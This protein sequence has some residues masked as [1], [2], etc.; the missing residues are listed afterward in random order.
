MQE[1]AG[2][3]PLSREEKESS[4]PQLLLKRLNLKRKPQRRQ[5]R[6][7]TKEQEQHQKYYLISALSGT[8]TKSEEIWLMDNG[9]SKHMT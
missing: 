1:I 5:T 6:A 4:K 7:A 3:L 9:A 2:T 8:I